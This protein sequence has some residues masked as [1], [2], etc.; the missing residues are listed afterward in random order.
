MKAVTL[1]QNSPEW[2]L[3]RNQGI[4]GSDAPVL[5]GSSPYSTPR[6]LYSI[7]RGELIE[8]QS[9]NEFIFA[10]GHRTE[11]LIRRNFQDLTGA[12][13]AP[14]CG[15][16]D[17]FEHIRSS[18]DG[19]DLNKYGVLEAKLVGKAVLEDAKEDGTIPRHHWV[20]IQHNI[21]VAG[22]DLGQWYGHNGSDNGIL[23]EIKRAPNFIR[24]QLEREHEF[25]GMVREGKLPP[26]SAD[27]EL[28]PSDLKLLTQIYEAKILL[29]N[30]QEYFDSLKEQL[31]SYNHPRLRGAGIVAYKSSR[32]GSLDVKKIPGVKSLLD[33]YT[34]KY[35]EKFRSSPSKP[36]WTVKME[37]EK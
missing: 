1:V 6:K 20:Q 37:T 30:A 9:G 22:V 18:F 3:W 5:E 29:D 11:A 36:S 32:Q 19:L 16:H 10:K 4:G 26:L 15:I 14:V 23:I 7:K 28:T 27:D 21:E 35:K 34:E 24:E 12:E 25:W 2:L 8:D 31:D 13:M 17:K 33:S